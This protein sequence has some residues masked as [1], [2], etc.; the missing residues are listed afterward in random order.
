[1][2]THQ[3]KIFISHSWHYSN[4]YETLVEWI[5]KTKWLVNKIPI[6]FLNLSVPKDDPIHNADND[7]EL[8]KEIFKIIEKSDVVVIPAGMYVGYSK[9]INKEIAGAK[10]LTKPILAVEPW[11]QEITPKILQEDSIP[12]VGWNEKSVVKGIWSLCEEKC[13]A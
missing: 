6:K 10:E 12:L 7:E 3:I 11:G 4:H 8:R 5:F 2:N 13:D 1:M 9:W